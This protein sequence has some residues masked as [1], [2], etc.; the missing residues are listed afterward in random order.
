M[1]KTMVITI[2]IFCISMVS[3]QTTAQKTTAS[4]VENFTLMREKETTCLNKIYS[5]PVYQPLRER[6]NNNPTLTQL[7]DKE[8]PTDEELRLIVTEH[9]ERAVCRTVIIEGLMNSVPGLIPVFVQYY[10]TNDLILA[11]LIERKINWGEG[12]KRLRASFL[13]L[14]TQAI[15]TVKQLERDLSVS[16]NNELAQ[17]QAA[18]NSFRQWRQNQEAL[19]QNQQ[20]I[21]SLNRPVITDC[22]RFGNTVNCRSR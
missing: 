1:K 3:C 10:N 13:E 14:Q 7:T 6:I 18:Y 2:V 5:N 15:S 22:T 16:H 8:L 20:M 9:N 11:D 17:R 21:D 12:N 4:I 19:R